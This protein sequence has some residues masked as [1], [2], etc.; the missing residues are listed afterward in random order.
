MDDDTACPTQM[1]IDHYKQYGS[2]KSKWADQGE[3][4]SNGCDVKT[5]FRDGDACTRDIPKQYVVILEQAA[6]PHYQ[7]QKKLEDMIDAE[8]QKVTLPIKPESVSFS[9]NPGFQSQS[10]WTWFTIEME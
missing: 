4:C 10:N 1:I 6:C 8:L 2:V 5:P 9:V 7:Y 3:A